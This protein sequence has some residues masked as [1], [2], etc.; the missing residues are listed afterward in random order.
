MR[1][2]AHNIGIVLAVSPAVL[3]ANTISPAIDL[4]GFESATVVISTG[5]IVAAGAFAVK[6]QDSATI[7]GDYVDVTTDR[8]IGTFPAALVADGV[9]KVG[10]VGTKR[11]IKVVL[12]RNSGTSIAAGVLV[13]KGHPSEAPVA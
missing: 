8:Q 10:Y 4:Q 11:F 3:A 5:A 1:D 7:G 2:L 12:T 9:V 13:I 6:L